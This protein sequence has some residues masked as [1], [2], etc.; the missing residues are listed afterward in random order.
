MTIIR[1][2]QQGQVPRP[3]QGER[4]VGSPVDELCPQP[5]RE[6]RCYAREDKALTSALGLFPGR[7]GIEVSAPDRRG[8]LRGTGERCQWFYVYE[9]VRGRTQ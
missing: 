7:C 4:G 9:A 2:P 3:E 6:H 5:A 8:R 1:P